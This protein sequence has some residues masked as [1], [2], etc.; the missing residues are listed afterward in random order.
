MS[1]HKLFGPNNY[2]IERCK[3]KKDNNLT[4]LAFYFPA[5]AHNERKKILKSAK[6]MNVHLLSSVACVKY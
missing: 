2:F 3:E 6:K 4:C 1:R 5:C